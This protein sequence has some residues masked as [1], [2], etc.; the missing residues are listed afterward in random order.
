M[1]KVFQQS[2]FDGTEQSMFNRSIQLIK[3]F[4]AV[5]LYRNPIGYAVGYSG[6]KD[7]DVLV[8]L[9]IKSG[10]KF[11]VFH[12]HTTLDAPE[13]VYHIRKKFKLWEGMGI[14]CK[15]FYPEQTF[16][17][18]CR[19]KRILPSRIIRFCCAEL[20]ER[21]I[22]ELKFATHSFG[23]RRA[24][25]NKRAMY[26]NSIE[27]RT[28]KGY[29][30]KKTFH[31]DNTEEVKASGACY[32]KK[33][34]IVNPIAYWSDECLWDYIESEKIEVNPLYN[35]GFRRIGCVGC[36]MAGKYRQEEFERYPKYKKMYIRLCDDII[37]MR[38]E[39]GLANKYNFKNGEEYFNFWLMGEIPEEEINLFTI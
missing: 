31:F 32:Q 19:K 1:D 15:I 16:W 14:P 35:E 3:E 7:S 6:G 21:E 13:T 10:C 36:P 9:F 17:S 34:F 39:N 20:K 27:L 5:A 30:D 38:K 2:I 33:H 4:E 26:R 29:S 11:M 22:P 23:V 24:E 37:A 28:T 8:D 12:N 18:L 25:S